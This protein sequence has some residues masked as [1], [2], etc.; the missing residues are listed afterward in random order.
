MDNTKYQWNIELTPAEDELGAVDIN[1]IFLLIQQEIY[2]SML[3]R[4]E[5]KLSIIWKI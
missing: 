1:K 4:I 5:E 2:T 3:Q